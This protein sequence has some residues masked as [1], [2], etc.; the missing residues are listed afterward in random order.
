M[1]DLAY[2]GIGIRFV[3]TVLDTIVLVA[4]GYLIAMPTGMTT[5]S[6]FA[7]QGGPAALWFLIGL[8]YFV[9]LEGTFGWTLGKRAV[10]IEVLTEEGESIDYRDSLIRNVLRVID[11]LFFYLVGAVFVFLSDEQQRLGDRVG[12]TVVVSA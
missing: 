1:A 9:L 12:N 3:A 6:G 4:I 2:R 11:G 5:A 7:L 10:G 8:A